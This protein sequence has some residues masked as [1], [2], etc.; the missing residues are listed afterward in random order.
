M[1]PSKWW[2]SPAS[3]R[4]RVSG[5]YDSVLRILFLPNSGNPLSPRSEDPAKFVYHK[6]VAI[7]T[8]MERNVLPRP[9]AGVYPVSVSSKVVFQD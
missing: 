8:K 4:L 6:E 5:R 9:Q 3:L 1:F 7:R 2:M